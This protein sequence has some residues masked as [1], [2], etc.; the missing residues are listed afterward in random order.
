MSHAVS[1]C[2]QPVCCRAALCQ[3]QT[4]VGI[5]GGHDKSVCLQECFHQL[6]LVRGSLSKFKFTRTVIQAGTEFLEGSV[7]SEFFEMSI[8]TTGPGQKVFSA[9]HTSGAEM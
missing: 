3:D 2:R 7:D 4:G 6:V 1:D 5:R 8:D 9:V